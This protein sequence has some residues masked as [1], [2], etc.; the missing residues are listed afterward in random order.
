MAADGPGRPLGRSIHGKRHGA[1]NTPS[2]EARPAS[3]EVPATA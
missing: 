3:P 1:K 2:T